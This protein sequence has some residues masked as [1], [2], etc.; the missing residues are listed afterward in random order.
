MAVK[1]HGFHPQHQTNNIKLEKAG[2]VAPVCSKNRETEA[3]SGPLRGLQE[4]GSTKPIGRMGSSL[5]GSIE[6]HWKQPSPLGASRLLR[7]G[8]HS[9]QPTW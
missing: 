3:D 7:E 8:A 6:F 4:I 1:G 9:H 2:T 5:A